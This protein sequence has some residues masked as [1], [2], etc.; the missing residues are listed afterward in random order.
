[1]CVCVCVCVCI[2]M[3]CPLSY[4]DQRSPAAN[5]L[6]AASD[7]DGGRFRDRGV[8][9]GNGT[10]ESSRSGNN[11]SSRAA[12]NGRTTRH[13]GGEQMRGPYALENAEGDI[14]EG[15]LQDAVW[16]SLTAADFGP[17]YLG[18]ATGEEMTHGSSAGGCSPLDPVLYGADTVAPVATAA[19]AP[20]PN[21]L[22][23]DVTAA[24]RTAAGK[25]ISAKIRIRLEQSRRVFGVADP[26]REWPAPPSPDHNGPRSPQQLLYGQCFFQPL[27]DGQPQSLVGGHI[28]MIRNP[29]Y[30]IGDVRVLEVVDILSCRHL[31][32]VLVLPVD[33]PRPTADESSGGDLDGDTFLVIWDPDFVRAV[34]RLPAPPYTAA[35]ERQA[36][37]V[38]IQQLISYFS[39]YRGDILGRIDRLYHLWAAIHPAGPRCS[40]CRALSQLFCRGVDSVSTGQATTIPSHLQLPPE[41]E[42]S[43]VERQ[44]LEDR[45]WK[46]MERRSEAVWRAFHDVR[47]AGLLEDPEGVRDLD[48]RGL[49]RLVRSRDVGLSEFELLRLMVR[50]CAG[51][52]GANLTEWAMHIDFATFSPEQR[53]FALAAGLPRHLVFN[54]LGQSALLQSEDLDAYQLGGE[55]DMH[56]KMLA[57]GTTD[58]PLAFDHFH[59]AL[60]AFQRKLLLMQ[61]AEP[62]QVIAMYLN[63]RFPMP[64]T[65]KCSQD[66]LVFAF[67]GSF[68][69]KQPLPS[70]N[71][72]LDLSSSRIQVYRNGNISQSFLWLHK[73]YAPIKPQAPVA[74]TAPEAEMRPKVG[75]VIR[76]ANPNQN[77]VPNYNEHNDP[78]YQQQRRAYNDRTNGLVERLP[79]GAGRG[80]TRD[81]AGGGSG[82]GAA[83]DPHVRVSIATIDLD[84]RAFNNGQLRKVTKEPLLRYELYVVSDREPLNTQSIWHLGGTEPYTPNDDGSDGTAAIREETG[85][86][87]PL[88]PLEVP[89]LP[90]E[91]L[92]L[93][94]L[95]ARAC[96]GGAVE[97]RA[98]AMAARL[99]A[100]GKL[101][102]AMRAARL[103]R[104]VLQADQL[105]DLLRA[106]GRF[107]DVGAAG[108]VVGW[109]L[110]RREDG[111]RSGSTAAATAGAGGGASGAEDTAASAANAP[112][113]IERALHVLREAAGSG[114]LVTCPEVIIRIWAEI[115]A[116]QD[117]ATTSSRNASPSGAGGSGGAAAAATAGVV[118][119]PVSLSERELELL[120]VA[121][122]SCARRQPEFVEELVLDIRNRVIFAGGCSSSSRSGSSSTVVAS[123]AHNPSSSAGC[124]RPSGHPTPQKGLV[125][126]APLSLRLQLLQKVVY[127][128]A[129][130]G[131]DH[132]AAVR[133]CQVLL[134]HEDLEGEGEGQ[135]ASDLQRDG[136]SRSSS[137]N[138]SNKGIGGKDYVERYCLTMAAALSYEVLTE[139]TETDV[140]LAAR[141]EEE[142]YG[143]GHDG[144][145][146]PPPDIQPGP[147]LFDYIATKVTAAD[148]HSSM[149]SRLSRVGGSGGGG[150]SLQ[151]V[152]RRWVADM[153]LRDHYHQFRQGL[154]QDGPGA[155]ASVQAVLELRNLVACTGPEARPQPLDPD[156]AGA[157]AGGGGGGGGGVDGEYDEIMGSCTAEGH[158]TYVA[159]RGVC[160]EGLGLTASGSGGG[161]GGD[162]D[163]GGG[164]RF[165]LELRRQDG[166]LIPAGGGNESSGI[167]VGDLVRLSDMQT[168]PHLLHRYL[169][170]GCDAAGMPLAVEAVVTSV[171]TVTLTLDLPWQPDI[172]EAD[173]S[174]AD[175]EAAVTRPDAAAAATAVSLDAAS[176]VGGPGGASRRLRSW[177]LQ[178]LGNVV[179]YER[180]TQALLRC[181]K[182]L[183]ATAHPLFNSPNVNLG[184]RSPVAT[185][186]EIVVRTWTGE[187]LN[188]AIPRT[189]L[190]GGGGGG[191]SDMLDGMV[192]HRGSGS[193]NA[194]VSASASAADAAATPV[195]AVAPEAVGAA[196][197]VAGSNGSQRA[198]VE[199]AAGRV[200]SII[201]GPPGTGKT[202]TIAALLTTLLLNQQEQ[203]KADASHPPAPR[204]RQLPI[205]I[206]AET[207]VAVD[208]ILD[209]LLRLVYDK[210][211]QQQQGKQGQQQGQQQQQ[212]H[213]ETMPTPPLL[214]ETTTAEDADPA[215]GA[216]TTG[217]ITSG[218]ASTA[219]A[220]GERG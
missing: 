89:A 47:A 18:A 144:A 154:D 199:A 142:R 72:W 77:L 157:A 27:V 214:R 12:G 102:P 86:C 130:G 141:A 145:A 152:A 113:R 98:A 196:C 1:M 104:H 137:S 70:H 203:Q 23:G 66:M 149:R 60:T 129:S 216:A 143:G 76:H 106:A 16:D 20:S 166:L 87:C 46:R 38:G 100:Q 194:A 103:A 185:P 56:W 127:I 210:K 195:A 2:C 162:C 206:T 45:V 79:A 189:G 200:L 186:L 201:H 128:A 4:T 156:L 131:V 73:G 218:S 109:M 158:D 54:A 30:D 35:P 74:L 31:E 96:N 95:E 160:A 123:L 65:Y 75:L 5:A 22:G 111:G 67:A 161:G 198:A 181:Q 168:P 172:Y 164:G 120:L 19:A 7:G 207:N 59:K 175:G 21:E 101:A 105:A 215:A 71:L 34:P 176:G 165:S 174:A 112:A 153:K 40:E 55:R 121:A 211:Q 61:M 10:A 6:E 169:R 78:N 133:L 50:W 49:M 180:G 220:K 99:A 13:G 178:R 69:H 202:T 94:H 97:V 51:R 14:E 191:G 192:G 90:E 68:R 63:E 208:N 36:G 146:A 134:N 212:Q 167:R 11:S 8:G 84:R 193:T 9:D 64:G 42:L 28:L 150:A 126:Q 58:N 83:G 136:S 217:S 155:M 3:F 15:P 37:E 119:P 179:T 151:D 204:Q 148:S 114:V 88:V 122:V 80:T 184:V 29:C 115:R 147:L 125:D 173:V 17:D 48:S 163:G 26:S 177:R 41:S 24:H 219:S 139:I 135:Q 116:V 107:H 182:Q 52:P 39:G 138:K 117:P 183:M 62:S 108:Q 132:D 93:G 91:L 110:E 197:R 124:Q 205:L 85:R 25:R 140:A 44:R 43:T 57:E 190:N 171:G 81:H 187:Q 170:G 33:G 209:R 53:L 188:V 32:D 118:R 159:P 92:Q 213:Q 82:R